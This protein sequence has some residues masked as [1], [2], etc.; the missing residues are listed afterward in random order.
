MTNA[1]RHKYMQG[2]ACAV[3]LAHENLKRIEKI[4]K[5]AGLNVDNKENMGY[6]GARDKYIP[7]LIKGE[8]K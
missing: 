2:M 6:I 7:V 3:F 8:A 5:D 4:A 1:E